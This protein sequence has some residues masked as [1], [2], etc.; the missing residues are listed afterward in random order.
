MMKY[1]QEAFAGAWHMCEGA[2]E[3]GAGAAD[4]HLQGVN[5]NLS[6]QWWQRS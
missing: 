1:L 6:V 5:L 4:T 2:R 3:V